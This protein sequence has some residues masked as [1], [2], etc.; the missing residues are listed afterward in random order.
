[1]S[2]RVCLA[3][4]DRYYRFDDEDTDRTGRFVRSIDIQHP[5]HDPWHHLSPRHRDHHDLV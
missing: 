5:R 2:L 4:L 1:M 3:W